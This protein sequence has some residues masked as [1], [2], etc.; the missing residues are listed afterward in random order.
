MDNTAKS[1][2][3]LTTMSKSVQDDVASVN[4]MSEEI[5]VMM[6]EQS[7][8]SNEILNAINQ[9]NNVTQSVSSGSEE[10]AAASEELLSQADSLR[11]REAIQA[12]GVTTIAQQQGR[13]I[14][15]GSRLRKN[16]L[17]KPRGISLQLRVISFFKRHQYFHGIF[18]SDAMYFEYA[19]PFFS[20]INC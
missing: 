2:I 5:S 20:F 14:T 11:Y 3:D 4:R 13:G 6:E 9:I 12:G 16:P 17:G 10:L 15:M 19:S 1:A 8:S 7:I 18:A